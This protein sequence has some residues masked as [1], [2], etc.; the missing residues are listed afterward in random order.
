MFFNPDLTKQAVE[1]QF[2]KKRIPSQHDELYFNNIPVKKVTETKHLGMTLDEK[3]SF[4]SHFETKISKANQELAVMKHIKKWVPFSTLV[5]YYKMWIRPHLE[6]GDVVFDKADKF[7]T[8]HNLVFGPTRSNDDFCV[9]L[10]SIQYQAARIATWAWKG[11]DIDKTYQLLGWES[12]EKRR[13]I[14]KL[15]ELYGIF[16]DRSPNHLYEII[17][18]LKYREGT[19]KAATLELVNTR[20]N[21]KSFF[22]STILDWNA[23]DKLEKDI[24]KSEPKTVF[25]KRLFNKARP[26]KQS[27]YGIID[28]NKIRYISM[29]RLELSPLNAHK[30]RRHFPDTPD[31]FCRVCHSIED[32]RHFLTLCRSYTDLRTNLYNSVSAIIGKSVFTIPSNTLVKMFLYGMENSTALINKAILEEV[33]KFIQLTKRFERVVTT[34]EGGGAT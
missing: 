6:Y 33:T 29:L 34:T 14:R 2:S 28:N 30:F 32:N 9:A 15:T 3:L 23:L 17:A 5:N 27:F 10:E 18:P 24:R 26:N 13:T 8:E 22:S 11:S 20:P 1:I 4:K 12:L 16:N 21:R 31:E 25:K 7:R 19:R